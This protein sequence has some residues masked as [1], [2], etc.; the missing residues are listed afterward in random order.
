MGS[1]V[2]VSVLIDFLS[3]CQPVVVFEKF[4][5]PEETSPA[6]P[7]ALR[8]RN[9]CL[10]EQFRV[11]V[12]RVASA[13]PMDRQTDVNIYIPPH[14]TP[15]FMWHQHRAQVHMNVN[16]P[17]HPTPQKRAKD[18]KN[19]KKPF[20]P[21]GFAYTQTR[22]QGPEGTTKDRGSPPSTILKIISREI[23]RR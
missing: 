2:S 23:H 10:P 1:Q 13:W 8:D 6:V 20:V 3:H 14:P 9:S 15:C 19:D 11:L 18:E 21:S 7:C 4:Q 16:I 22:A 5:R 17:S 12:G